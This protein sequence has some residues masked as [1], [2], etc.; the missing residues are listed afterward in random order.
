MLHL[1]LHSF[2]LTYGLTVCTHTVAASQFPRQRRR[3]CWWTE[4]VLT[5][6]RLYTSTRRRT[7]LSS[8]WR[9]ILVSVTVLVTLTSTLPGH[10]ASEVTTIRRCTNMC[11]VLL[12]CC[13]VLYYCFLWL[14]IHACAPVNMYVIQLLCKRTSKL[15]GFTTCLTTMG[16]HVPCGMAHCYLPPCRGDIPALTLAN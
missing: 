4:F 12:L 7:T 9:I 10:S 1:C 6:C 3:Q 16:T 2:S 13:I 5:S 8:Q 15:S 14:G 11:I